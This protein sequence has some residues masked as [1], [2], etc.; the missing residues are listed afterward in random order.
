[1]D[2]AVLKAALT[3]KF[4]EA[5]EGACKAVDKAPDG[6]WIAASE[7]EVRE[8][9]QRLTAE[10][11]QELIQ[12]RIDAQPPPKTEAAFSPDRQFAQIVEQRSASHPGFER[13]G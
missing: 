12:Q 5:L 4:H 9:F 7:W 2:K 10:C 11:Y 8:L 6:A 3:R 13:R 1:M